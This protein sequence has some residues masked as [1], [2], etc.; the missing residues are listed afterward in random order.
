[1]TTT[2]R[3]DR[4]ILNTPGRALTPERR[5]QLDALTNVN[6]DDML[7]GVGLEHARRGTGLLRGLLRGRAQHFARKIIYYDD[8][9]G[10]RG[11]AAGGAW[12]VA[13]FAERLHV[14]D[15]VQ[16]PRSGAALIVANHP[17]L[18]DT[19]ALFAAIDRPDLL[20]VAAWRPFLHALPHTSRHLLY[21]DDTQ[22][23]RVA[24]AR[25]AARHLRGGGAVLTFPGG[26]IEPDPAAQGGAAAA[27]DRWGNSVAA[28]ARLAPNAVVV[29][30]IVSGVVSPAAL[31]H[32]LTRIR[33]QP[34]DRQW[35][36]GLL[37]LQLRSLQ[38]VV[39]RVHFG[40]PLAATQPNMD[41]AVRTQAQRLIANAASRRAD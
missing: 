14:M 41:D 34:N 30:T 15:Q 38:H 11:L 22:R 32:P 18:C 29:P 2:D 17:G 7:R 9:V 6:I 3:I 1:M 28:F 21:V 33:R 20:I 36:A 10:A 27:L 39:V 13:Q 37:Q 31:R 24:A 8:L 19:M 4:T 16:V 23:S 5:V 25:A 40:Q 26:Q 35:L 12:A